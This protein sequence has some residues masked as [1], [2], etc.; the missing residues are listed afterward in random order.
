[1]SHLIETYIDHLLQ[2]PHALPPQ[3]MDAETAAFAR[4]LVASKDK[5][6]AAQRARIWQRSLDAAR[7]ASR[8]HN[9]TT[10]FHPSPNGHQVHASPTYGEKPMTT[11]SI[12]VSRPHERGTSTRLMGILPLAAAIVFVVLGIALLSSIPT[13]SPALTTPPGDETHGSLLGTESATPTAVP[14][15]TPLPLTSISPTLVRGASLTI[16]EY[17]IQP[18][19]TLLSILV[20]FGFTDLSVLSAIQALNPSFPI[21]QPPA[22]GTTILIPLLPSTA[23]S[24]MVPVIVTA[25]PIPVLPSLVNGTA[26]PVPIEM[27]D[28]PQPAPSLVPS[29][30]EVYV[31]EEGDTL[32]EILSRFD[33]TLKMFAE[34]NPQLNFSGCDFSRLSGGSGCALSLTVG[35][36]INVPIYDEAGAGPGI[37][38]PNPTGSPTPRPV[39]HSTAVLEPTAAPH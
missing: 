20:Q 22:P 26:T 6:S 31:I 8:A 17:T 23:I 25:T 35:D 33:I 18:G 5:P 38:Y 11:I 7:T 2:D 15:S 21:D 19:D 4:A 30:V 36:E 3:G 16:V 34:L 24:S 32:L 1:M 12:P 29:R 10:V 27:P 28:L 37:W 39:R 14:S 13:T 9:Q